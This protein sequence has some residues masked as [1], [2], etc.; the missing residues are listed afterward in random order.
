MESSTFSNL[1]SEL[2]GAIYV[3]DVT[4]NKRTTDTYT[5]YSVIGSTFKNVSAFAGGAI[6]LSYPQ[7][8]YILNSTFQNSRALNTTGSIAGLNTG[9]GGAIF[10]ECGESDTK[11]NLN[12]TGSTTFKNNFAQK[13]GGAIHW[14]Y[15]EPIMGSNLIFSSN[16]AGWYGDDISCYAQ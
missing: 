14:N 3:E 6:Y 10:Y 5:K 2:G 4:L 16:E 13:K 12:I 15:F 11:C 9:S 1:K 8:F 7:Y